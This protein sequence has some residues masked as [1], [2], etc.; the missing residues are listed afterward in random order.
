MDLPIIAQVDLPIE[1]AGNYS[2]AIAID[3][4]HTMDVGIVVRS[5]QPIVPKGM[6][7]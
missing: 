3:G 1:S 6:V 7:S 4:D 2:M 5:A